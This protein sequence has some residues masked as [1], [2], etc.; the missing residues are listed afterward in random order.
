MTKRMIGDVDQAGAKDEDILLGQRIISAASRHDNEALQVLL[1]HGSANVRDPATGTT[2]L[3]AAIA[4]FE[5]ANGDESDLSKNEAAAAQTLELLLHNGAI[6]N[7]LNKA[8]ETPGCLALRLGRKKLYDVMVEAGVRAELLFS[9]LGALGLLSE[10]GAVEREEV[11][12]DEVSDEQPA[13]KV[14]VVA[15]NENPDSNVQG[16]PEEEWDDVSRD[17]FRYLKSELRY[18]PGILLDESDNAVMMDW[19]TEIMTRHTETLA[20]KAG[21]R[22]MNIGHG[23]GIVDRAFLDRSPEHHHIIEAHPQVH[24]RMRETGWYDKPNVTVHEGRWQDVVPKLVEQGVVLDAIYY[25]TFAEDYN[26]LKELFSDWVVQLLDS[27][28]KFG[29]YNGL[30]ADR[31]ICYDVYTKVRLLNV[32]CAHCL[33]TTALLGRG[34]GSFRS[35]L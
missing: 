13:Q 4:A 34:N 35:W 32:N 5:T 17:N 12:I 25:D 1:K 7:D 33:L 19:E 23:M 18:K 2:P 28:G 24:R 30:G 22:T 6:W 31:Q 14:Q 3:H 21:L 29:W 26:A 27:N 16:Q 20:P 11:E 15:S 8:D 10:D 9:K